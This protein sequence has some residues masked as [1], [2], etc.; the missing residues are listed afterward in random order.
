MENEAKELATESTESPSSA[1]ERRPSIVISKMLGVTPLGRLHDR[2]SRLLYDDSWRAP[3]QAPQTWYEG[4]L[5]LNEAFPDG[6]QSLKGWQREVVAIWMNKNPQAP[7]V[8]ESSLQPE[9]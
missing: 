6:P 4:T 9:V 7:S 8:A 1:P 3:E 5:I 2:L